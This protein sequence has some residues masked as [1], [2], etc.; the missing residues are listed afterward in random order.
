MSGKNLRLCAAGSFTVEASMILFSVFLCI[1]LVLY[2]CMFLH[3]RNVL[4][5]ASLQAARRGRLQISDCEDPF[6]GRISWEDYRSRGI[7][8]MLGGSADSAETVLYA[9]SIAAGKLASCRTPAFSAVSSVRTCTVTYTASVKL[10]WLFPAITK[11]SVI[12]GKASVSALKPE[13][14]IRLIHAVRDEK[15]ESEEG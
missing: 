2:G 4:Y 7:L 10:P 5:T 1:F 3:D 8:W 15:Q 12:K 6:T 14:M 9:E 13:E 11:L